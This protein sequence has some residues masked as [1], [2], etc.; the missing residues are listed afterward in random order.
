MFSETDEKLLKQ[1]KTCRFTITF[2]NM[3]ASSADR[4]SE[5]QNI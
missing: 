5:F 2:C 3:S 4:I 1:E